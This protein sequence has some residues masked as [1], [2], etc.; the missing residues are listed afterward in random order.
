MSND[1]PKAMTGAERR[2]Y[3]A[4]VRA[5]GGERSPAG[6]AFINAEHQKFKAA[7][8]AHNREAGLWHRIWHG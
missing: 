4:E 3:N 7:L 1:C 8:A 6:K 2:A 5:R